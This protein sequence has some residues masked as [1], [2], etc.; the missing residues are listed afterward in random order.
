MPRD[1]DPNIFEFELHCSVCNAKETSQGNLKQHY[2]ENGCRQFFV[3]CGCYDI[4]Y[5]TAASLAS[6]LNMRGARA[7]STFYLPAA[8]IS[9]DAAIATLHDSPPSASRPPN[10]LPSTAPAALGREPDCSPSVSLPPTTSS[11]PVSLPLVIPSVCLCTVYHSDCFDLYPPLP[12]DDATAPYYFCLFCTAYC[13]Y[14]IIYRYD[15]YLFSVSLSPF[16]VSQ[17]TPHADPNLSP[18]VLS[19]PSLTV[20]PPTLTVTTVD[21]SAPSTP[22]FSVPD[23]AFSAT[24]HL[25]TAADLSDFD[26]ISEIQPDSDRAASLSPSAFLNLPP[27]SVVS[28]I[29]AVATSSSYL[30]ART[31]SPR[32]PRV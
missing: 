20:H 26:A 30:A 18:A 28:S 4:T 16:S 27:T 8:A 32:L 29:P 25:F 1:V 19:L 31:H 21:L 17:D 2:K 7:R 11:V 3:L 6:H 10:R 5:T 15:S 13:L 12:P 14:A 23:S 22:P 24:D 9:L